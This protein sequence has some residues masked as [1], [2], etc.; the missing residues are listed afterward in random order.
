[1]RDRIDDRH[2]RAG[3]QRQMVRRFHMRHA[4]HVGLARIDHD[5][6]RAAFTDAPL[7]ARSEHRMR[8]G[9][10]GAD[11]QHH[12]GFPNRVEILRAGG[13]AERRLQAIARRRM[14]DARAGVDIVVAE[15]RADH[16]LH[17]EGLFVGAA[18]RGDAADR[19]LAVFRLDA[20]ELGR[21]V[22]D[23]LVPG[24]FAPRVLDR[25]ADHR[26][27]D[28]LFVRR[29]TPGEAA[30]H[31]GMAVI[32][33]AVLVR[34]H[35]HDAVALKL[36]L[37][38]AADAAIGAGGDHRALRRA[39]LDDGLLHQRRRRAG[40]HAGAARD[41]LGFEEVL[42]HAGRDVAREAAVVDRQRERAL[43]FFAGANAARADDALRRIEGEIRVRLV[44]RLMGVVLAVIAVADFAQTHRARHVLQLAVAVGGAG[45]AVQRMVA[46]V[47]FHDPA[48]QLGDA[49]G[50]GVDLHAVLGGRRAGRGRSTAAVDL[51]QA[52]A[53]GAEG[54]ERV[55][56]AE[57]G[58]LDAG[59]RCGPHQRRAG[60]N[61][62]R[63]AVDVQ[64]DA[65]HARLLG[66]PPV[67]HGLVDIRMDCHGTSLCSPYYI[68]RQPPRAKAYGQNLQGNAQARS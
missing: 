2:V 34:R 28:A 15:G 22:L 67:D 7:H 44:L 37:E 41:A 50:L 35:A 27:G 56:G 1:M 26:L 33:L 68:T 54:F 20:L 53:A 25:G 57:L 5:H 43:D 23:R 30:L 48:P 24:H 21:R 29:I 8:I 55:G 66:G 47:E 46:D 60:R 39:V 58:N 49:I 62:D 16:L 42:V 32:G 45:Q 31:A 64:A 3:L 51:D 13:R 38:G 6:L 11:D 61:R 65:L 40:L 10:V 19:A 14:A 12:V 17:H 52:Q 63:D 36:G 59:E 18:R 4:H 9:R